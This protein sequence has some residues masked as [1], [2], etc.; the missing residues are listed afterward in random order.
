MATGLGFAGGY[1]QE[2]ADRDVAR[3]DGVWNKL[4][5]YAS[6]FERNKVS[7]E[8]YKK[9]EAYKNVAGVAVRGVRE[10][11]ESLVAGGKTAA[12]RKSLNRTKKQRL[13][14]T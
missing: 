1:T 9:V 4:E 5:K 6:V 8:E 14:I 12:F 3:L 7:P 10:T 11:R 2:R 13:A